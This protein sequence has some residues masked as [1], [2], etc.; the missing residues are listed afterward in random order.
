MTSTTSHADPIARLCLAPEACLDDLIA[1]IAALRG[2][3]LEVRRMTL[4]VQSDRHGI[5]VAARRAD[6]LV[7]ASTAT[8]GAIIHDLAHVLCE[9]TSGATER[10]TEVVYTQE[11]EHEAVL[12]A[13]RLA[14]RYPRLSTRAPGRF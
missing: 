9:H 12:I 14:T 8:P 2:R 13:A 1:A 5:W 4:A 11:Q 10:P 6:H 3:S 7:V